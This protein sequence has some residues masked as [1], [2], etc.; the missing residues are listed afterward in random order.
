MDKNL[1][2]IV[3]AVIDGSTERD[4]IEPGLI[5][6]AAYREMDA[7]CISPVLVKVAALQALKQIARRLLRGRYEPDGDDGEMSLEFPGLQKRY[8]VAHN[9]GDEPQYRKLEKLTDADVIYNANRL[10]READSKI[11]HARALKLWARRQ[12]IIDV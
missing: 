12:G 9:N 8:P 7:D 1:S 2:N 5:A 4:E 3:S 11:K 6:A 10:E